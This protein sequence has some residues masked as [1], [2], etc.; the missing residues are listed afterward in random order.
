MVLSINAAYEVIINFN[1]AYNPYCAYNEKYSC[2][3][4]PGENDLPVAIM[5]GVKLDQQ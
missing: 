4:V 1:L 2:P 3:L 5:A